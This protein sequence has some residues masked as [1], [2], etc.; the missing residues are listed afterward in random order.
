[1]A[2]VS[3]VSLAISGGA[4]A[5]VYLFFVVLL[6]SGTLGLILGLITATLA[7]IVRKS[8]RTGF[9]ISLRMLEGSILAAVII[10]T[11]SCHLIGPA[12]FT[13]LANLDEAGDS[14]LGLTY[15]GLVLWFAV[16]PASLIGSIMAGI[17]GYKPTGYQLKPRNPGKD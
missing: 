13:E 16:L 4:V 10:F 6:L 3:V 9:R 8:L 5:L 11:I 15:H 14:M 1:M 2:A 7:S 17:L 12:I